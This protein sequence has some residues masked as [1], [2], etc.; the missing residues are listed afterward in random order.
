[1]LCGIWRRSLHRDH[2][3]PKF[4]GGGN[5]PENIQLICAN[6]HEDKTVMDLTGEALSLAARTAREN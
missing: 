5:E 4:K 1:L 6:C 2:I 3:V